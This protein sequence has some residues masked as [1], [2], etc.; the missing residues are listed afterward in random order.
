MRTLLLILAF[1][2]A[3]HQDDGAGT[4]PD[5]N[6]EPTPPTTPPTGC[7]LLADGNCVEETYHNPPV[8]GPDN[9]G[10]YQLELAPTEVVL[11]G[12][13]HCVRAYNGMFPGPTIETAAGTDRHV[14]VDL[15]NNLLAHD[16]H[17]LSG[18]ATCACEDS[19]GAECI[20][21]HHDACRAPDEDCVCTN[22]EGEVCEEMAD[23]NVT[24]LHAH[25]S[26]TH[27]DYSRGGDCTP[28]GQATCRECG[29]E[30]CDGD[31]SDDLCFFG[32]DVLSAVHPAEGARYR[33]DIDEDGM[34][35]EGMD[36]YHPHIHGTTAI[37]VASGAAGAWLV[38]GPADTAPGV[39]EA[40]ERVMI[41]STPPI[42]E[43]GFVPLEDGEDCREETLTFDDFS[44][45][46]TTSAPQRNIV[47]GL[48]QPRMIAAPGQV[49]RWRMLDA[50]FLDEMYI[51]VFRGSDSDCS[52]WSVEDA[53]TL[54]FVQ[55]ER[56]GILLP[57]AFPSDYLFLSPGYRIEGF[58]GG[59][60]TFVDGDTWC[61]V[62]GRFLQEDTS[63]DPFSEGP[64]DPGVP[65]NPDAIDAML[66]GGDLV[67]LLSVTASA[68]TA[69]TTALPD[70]A[71][72]ADLAP[73]TEIQGVSAEQRCADAAAV[74][75]P[76]AIDQ[77]AVMQV[78]FWTADEPDPCGCANHNLNCSNF[79]DIDRTVY[80][81]DRDLPLG[82]VENW[83]I[84]ASVDGHPFHIHINPFLVC[85]DANPFDPIPFP[86]WRDTF[87]VNGDREVD[88]VTEYKSYTGAYVLHCHKLTHEDEGMMQKLRI[89][90]PAEDPTCGDYGW[91]KC[92]DGDLTCLQHLAAT[93]CAIAAGS[94]LEEAACSVALG[95]P[96]GICGPNACVDTGDC[97][98]PLVCTDDVCS[99]P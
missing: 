7:F 29:T 94:E 53:D 25:G 42:G 82:A 1:S 37:Q 66:A 48:R 46:S 61:V 51:G 34:H 47:N 36:W 81:F 88:L 90:D 58:I 78:G 21:N 92:A 13:R 96:T 75:D 38:R 70:L 72:L 40:T 3:C 89:C 93:D 73:S 85:P 49:E 27:P 28:D 69:T 16:F 87:L 30:T 95:G 62:M 11:D 9:Q 97:N 41:L 45:L 86:H 26:H 50:G 44:R 43:N 64:G 12:E 74:T 5:T 63:D 19:T 6:A 80:P 59:E 65:P 99:P 91:R 83:R 77:A 33:W 79:E 57:E 22:S 20:P 67:A 24:N 60:G 18:D 17:D 84:S 35:H 15:R 10:V 39:A 68:G 98:F 76:E 56:D 23:F 31:T 71:A 55:T 14:R 8:L 54:S 4:P 52:S 2:A 32:D